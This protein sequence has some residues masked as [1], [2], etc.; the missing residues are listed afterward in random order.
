MNIWDHKIFVF[1]TTDWST[2]SLLRMVICQ[3]SSI[4]ILPALINKTSRD[5]TH[6]PEAKIPPHFTFFQVKNL[7]LRFKRSWLPSQPFQTRL[8]VNKT[9]SNEKK[10]KKLRWD[11]EFSKPYFPWLHPDILHKNHKQHWRRQKPFIKPELDL[12]VRM[13]TQ[14]CSGYTGT[15]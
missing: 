2:P 7:D 13:S 9:T 5:F 4:S 11:L 14:S 1:T 6:S 12:V 3:S 10:K 15:G 8:H